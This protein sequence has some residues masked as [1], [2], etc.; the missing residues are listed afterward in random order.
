MGTSSIE[1]TDV[2]WNPVTGCSKVSA[3]CKH[4]Y[5]ETFAGRQMGPWKGRAF[6]DVRCHE[7]RLEQPLHWRTP[8]RVFVNSMSDLFHEA[9]PDAFID[10]VFAVMALTP[11]HT[12]Q[13]LTKRPERMREYFAAPTKKWTFIVADEAGQRWPQGGPR[14]ISDAL[15]D[16]SVPLL[17]M[18]L[19]VSV[20]DQATANTRI[21]L[22]LQT[23]AALRFV[24]AE[25]LLGPVDLGMACSWVR[26]DIPGP[27]P[28]GLQQ[29]AA[30][31]GQGVSLEFGNV[32]EPHAQ[33][34][35][36]SRA[37]TRHPKIDWLIV[38]GESGPKARSCDVA[39]IRSIVRQ[40]QAADCPVFVKQ[41][42]A[43]VVDRNDRF[44]TEGPGCEPCDPRD[45]PEPE[46]GWDDGP[47]GNLERLD[48]GYQGAPV[49]IRLKSRKGNYPAE[50][51]ADIR[52][53]EFPEVQR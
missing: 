46:R 10:R 6:T 39:W 41:V 9:V 42:G 27:A 13:V 4:C 19:G 11:Q 12:Y 22:L 20:E 45:W 38:G 18:W 32:A 49:R 35:R 40:C 23:P 17:N 51:P 33:P 15:C 3:G 43:Y 52:V 5:A 7:D 16:F 36:S 1:W 8:R 29:G 50:W 53:R 14:R 37:E 2:V 25:P 47:R 48:D 44:S 30:T 31:T 24:S 34:G 21:P 26:G 28:K